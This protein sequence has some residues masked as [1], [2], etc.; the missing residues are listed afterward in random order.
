MTI[1]DKLKQIKQSTDAIK[2]SA[3]ALTGEVQTDLTSIA[4]ILD[5]ANPASATDILNMLGYNSTNAPDLYNA[6]LS[7]L[8]KEEG[9]SY[10][11]DTS[12]LLPKL[13]LDENGVYTLTSEMFQNSTI[14]TIPKGKYNGISYTSYDGMFQDCANL[15]WI[16]DMELISDSNNYTCTRM[17]YGCKSLRTVGNLNMNGCTN[18]YYM[19]Y[20]CANLESITSIDTSNITNMGLMFSGCTKLKSIPQLNTSNATDM[21]SMFGNCSTLESIPLLDTS[22]VTNMTSMFTSCSSLTS[23]PQLNTSNVTTMKTMFEACSTLKSIPQLNTSKVT[24]MSNMF[25]NCYE[26]TSVPQLDY[27]SVTNM[28][29]SFNYCRALITT[30]D[31]NFESATNLT[32]LFSYSSE[33][34]TVGNLNTPNITSTSSIFNKCDKLEKIASIDVRSVTTTT[35]MFSYNTTKTLKYVVFK[36]LG[37]STANSWSF[38]NITNWGVNDDKYPDAK[39]SLID[40]LITY[41][42]DRASAGMSACTITLSSTTRA[43][44]T[45]DEITQIATKGYTIA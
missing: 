17:F 37:Q 25:K 35:S 12:V 45:D 38:V 18:A 2:A 3:S 33:L 27:S 36:N 29:G 39:Q 16:P 6:F 8:D 11:G 34:V 10:N 44:L 14:L 1:A 13:T 43:L 21:T 40:S 24:D 30:P 20:G 32:G 4:I 42:Y 19:F 23:V 26:L 28:S 41:S 5:T 15:L 31:L 7:S 9:A 22:N